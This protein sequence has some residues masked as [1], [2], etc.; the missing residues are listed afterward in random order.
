MLMSESDAP[1]PEL[2]ASCG[3]CGD[4]FRH[5]LGYATV[6]GTPRGGGSS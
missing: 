4:T 1:G 2:R 3:A 5:G 6:M